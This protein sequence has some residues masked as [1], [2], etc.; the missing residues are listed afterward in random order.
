MW[1]RYDCKTLKDYYDLY[2]TLDVT[3]LA[4]VFENF[5]TMAIRE[6]KL[7]PAHLWTV[8]G[9]AWNCALGMSKT[10]LEL[11]TDPDMFLVFQN[12][13]RGEISTISHRYAKANN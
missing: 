12:S 2:L 1:R 5:R 3:L 13:I 11:I 7:D 10:E 6:Y 8:L 4:D 9:F